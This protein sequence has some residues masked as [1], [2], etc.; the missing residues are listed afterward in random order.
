M[1]AIPLACTHQSAPDY[2][3]VKQ[4]GGAELL[5]AQCTDSSYIWEMSDL[6]IEGTA[7]QV[8]SKWDEAGTSIF[9]YTVI[10]IDTYLKGHTLEQSSVQIVTPGGTV[11]DIGQGVEDQPLFHKGHRVRIYLHQQEGQYSVVCGTFGVEQI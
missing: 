9:T 11:G 6:I 2:L 10:S 1:V 4:A 8:E 7:E 5:V 3:V